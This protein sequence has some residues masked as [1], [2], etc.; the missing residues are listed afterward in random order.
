MCSSLS[1]IIVYFHY[2]DYFFFFCQSGRPIRFGRRKLK[3]KVC[4]FAVIY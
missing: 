2:H 4:E 3:E 1:G